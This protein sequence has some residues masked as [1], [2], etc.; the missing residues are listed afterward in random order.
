MRGRLAI[1]FLTVFIDLL[2]FGLVIPILPTYAAGMGASSFEVGL[3]MAVYALMTFIFSPFWG[4]VG[5]RMGRRPVIAFTVF[6]T[7]GAFLL[8]A[9]ADNLFLLLAAR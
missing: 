7:A 5:V 2:G 1:L 4:T 9:H 3:I 6:V 8:L